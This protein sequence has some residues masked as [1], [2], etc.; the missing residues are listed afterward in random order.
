[1]VYLQNSGD[2]LFFRSCGEQRGVGGWTK[3]VGECDPEVLAALL[4]SH[5]EHRDLPLN[6]HTKFEQGA[7]LHVS[8]TPFIEFGLGS[9]NFL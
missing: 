3:V 2:E 5:F 6:F 1:M 9:I 8:C 4:H 7:S